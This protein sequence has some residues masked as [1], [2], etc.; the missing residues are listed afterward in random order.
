MAAF[1]NQATL[2]YNGYVTNSNVTVGEITD[3][4]GIT[5]TSLSDS[6]TV[7]DTVSYVIGITNNGGALTGLT[8][9][10]NLGSYVYGTGTLTPLTYVDGTA[11][12]YVNGVLQATPTVTAGPPLTFSG[13]NI[14]EGA[15]ALIVYEARVNSFAPPTVSSE[16]TNTVTVTGS[17]ITNP[18][19]ATNTV[20]V[21]V[22][23]TLS[24]TKSLSPTTVTAGSEVTYTFVVQNLGN[25]GVE[26]TDNMTVSDTFDPALSGI[27]VVFNG[28]TLTEGT[29]YSY[30]EATGAFTTLDG[31][32]YVPAA[33]FTQNAD[34]SYTATP[35][36]GVLTVT[37]TV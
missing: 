2:S 30:D 12:Y 26:A 7:G 9:S 18:Q 27:T 5:K 34:G 36:I 17:G 23:P 13:L 33:T 15:N 31:T 11:K 35:G 37:G 24:I 28:T 29:G 20:T 1:Y 4:L 19:S 16:I 22:Q 21:S 3:S 14:P 8:V 32:L 6:Y 10:D 25:A